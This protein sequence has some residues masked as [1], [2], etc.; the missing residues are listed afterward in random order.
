MFSDK[1]TIIEY[2]ELEGT[3]RIIESVHLLAPHRTTQKSDHMSESIVQMLLELRQLCAMTTVLSSPFHAHHP[4]VKNLLLTPNLP[5]PW[6]SSMP[7]PRALLLSQRAELSAAPPLPVRVA[8]TMRPPLSSSALGWANRGTSAASHTS[9]ALDLPHLWTLFNCFTHVRKICKTEMG[10]IIKIREWK[11]NG[12]NLRTGETIICY[13]YF[14]STTPVVLCL[15]LLLFS[16]AKFL[17]GTRW[18]TMPVQQN[19]FAGICP[20]DEVQKFYRLL[21]IIITF[22]AKSLQVLISFIT[23]LPR[24]Q[25]NDFFFSAVILYL[26]RLDR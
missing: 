7:F 6:H 23:E 8:A 19:Q 11:D 13:L 16:A 20:S 2:L 1:H 21:C 15:A 22:M 25:L 18:S 26:Y 4:L 3:I 14:S 9:T 10:A 17:Q 24:R 5:L 12:E